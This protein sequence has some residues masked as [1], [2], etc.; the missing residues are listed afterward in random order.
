LG[1]APWPQRVA[2]CPFVPPPTIPAPP[3]LPPL[4]KTQGLVF[5][6]PQPPAPSGRR[7]FAPYWWPAA[8][9]GNPCPG[10]PLPKEKRGIKKTASPQQWGP[11]KHETLCPPS[12][13]GPPK[14]GLQTNLKKPHNCFFP[15]ARTWPPLP[16]ENPIYPLP[17]PTTLF[18]TTKQTGKKEKKV[19][20]KKR[21]K[22]ISPVG[23]RASSPRESPPPPPPLFLN[24]VLSTCFGPPK[25][26]A[27]SVPPPP[28]PP[29]VFGRT[30]TKGPSPRNKNCPSPLACPQRPKPVGVLFAKKA[31]PRR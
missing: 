25:D 8:G 14:W 16:G 24:V 1:S 13:L 22:N 17:S 3:P 27:Q 31:P 18:N 11:R 19:K 30:A 9:G 12:P 29:C 20:E 28:R 7:A 6:S 2:R 4:K 10:P 5:V 15:R 23:R 21:R 26:R